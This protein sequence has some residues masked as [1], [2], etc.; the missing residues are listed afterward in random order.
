[1]TLKYWGKVFS[2]L[3]W[4]DSME[5]YMKGQAASVM[6][7]LEVLCCWIGMLTGSEVDMG[8]RLRRRK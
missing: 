7:L 4:G 6:H 5:K 3:G 8:C 2:L 1:M